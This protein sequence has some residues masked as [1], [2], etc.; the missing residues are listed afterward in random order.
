MFEN[1]SKPIE[2]SALKL[3]GGFADILYGK[4]SDLSRDSHNREVI[5]PRDM[6]AHANA[7][8]EWWYYTGH[9]KTASGKRF[10]FE[11]VFFKRQ[12]DYDRLGIL[13]L[14]LLANPMYAAHFAITDIDNKSFQ[15]RDRKSFL[16][17]V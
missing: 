8:T 10:G 14:R 1:V 7:Q 9:C 2:T 15:F 11:L 3:L 5:L 17:S 13:P 6:Y 4:P 12:T 16:M